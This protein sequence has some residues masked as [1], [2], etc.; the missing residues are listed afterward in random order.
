M[1]ERI[2]EKVKYNIVKGF[3]MISKEEIRKLGRECYD[4]LSELGKAQSDYVEKFGEFPPSIGYGWN[5][6]SER[7][8]KL[9][10]KAIATG[11]KIKN[12]VKYSDNI[13]Y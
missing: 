9:L 7:Y 1:R 2:V 6:S 11:K 8:V 10:R 5:I 3:N 12:P 13:L 4:G